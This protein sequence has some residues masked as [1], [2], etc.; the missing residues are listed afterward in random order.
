MAYT[1]RRA[2]RKTR[3]AT[4]RGRRSYGAGGGRVAG[5]RTRA[6]RTVRSGR[7]RPQELRI[8]VVSEPADGTAAR[9]PIPAFMKPAPVA[10]PK[11]AR[12]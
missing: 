3:T 12:F 2:V 6:A 5:K 11:K 4:T 7:S 1:R 9:P 10:P 8:T